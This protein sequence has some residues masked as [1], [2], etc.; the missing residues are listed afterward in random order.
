MQQW[1]LWGAS[2]APC[3]PPPARPTCPIA[4][5]P[6][7]SFACLPAAVQIWREHQPHHSLFTAAMEAAGLHV[8][9]RRS[10]ACHC[11]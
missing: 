7:C 5:L 4:R 10:P 9:V 6:T 8:E 3:A 2:A 1:R 11:C